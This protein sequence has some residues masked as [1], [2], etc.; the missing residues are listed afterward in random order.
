[1]ILSSLILAHLLFA[2]TVLIEPLLG[3]RQ[4]RE[5][6]QRLR[7]DPDARQRF[8]RRIL[9][10][11]WA[12]VAVIGLIL[13]LAPS[14]LQAIGLVIPQFN[15][16]EQE[17]ML[18]LVLAGALGLL[19][20]ILGLLVLSR[21]SPHLARRLQHKLL[22]SGAALLPATSSERR[23]WVAVALTAGICEEL[24]FRGFLLLYLAHFFSALPRWGAM[25]ISA[26]VFGLAH[27]YQGWKGVVGTGL[28]GLGLA[29]V[30]VV[31]GSLLPS[32]ALHA[33]VDLRILVLWRPTAHPEPVEG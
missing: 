24:L 28:L 13:P 25:V 14:P 5:L 19:V 17:F 8:Y 18:V 12:W 4:Y 31:T 7:T 33:L 3:V 16:P 21:K 32:M 11:E 10:I 29:F 26:A 20:P 22:E 2:Y 6:R 1:M 9:L 23:T 15:G 27:A 30:Y